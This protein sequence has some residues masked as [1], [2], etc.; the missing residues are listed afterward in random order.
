MHT[1]KFVSLIV[2]VRFVFNEMSMPGF[3]IKAGTSNF[4]IPYIFKFEISSLY[5][6]SC[7]YMS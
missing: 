3:Q 7:I 4:Y 6:F 5:F 1:D 2:T